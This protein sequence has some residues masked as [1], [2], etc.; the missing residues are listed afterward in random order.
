MKVL[1]SKYVDKHT[2]N[3]LLREKEKEKQNLFLFGVA[4]HPSYTNT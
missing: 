2:Q 4:L 1:N 3:K